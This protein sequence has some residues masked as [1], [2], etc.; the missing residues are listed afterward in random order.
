MT[1]FP[2]S[3]FL[4]LVFATAVVSVGASARGATP[5]AGPDGYLLGKVESVDAAGNPRMRTAQIEAA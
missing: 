5:A 1:L 4:A 3:A 2:R